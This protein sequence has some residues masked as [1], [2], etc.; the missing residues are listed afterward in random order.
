MIVVDL[1]GNKLLGVEYN[2]K[3]VS[4]ENYKAL[5]ELIKW[6]NVIT[7]EIEHVGVSDLK[8]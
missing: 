1:G 5:E 3:Q 2:T 6:H 8:E 7:F 4:L